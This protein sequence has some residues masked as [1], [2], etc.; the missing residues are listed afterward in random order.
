MWSELRKLYGP[1]VATETALAERDKQ[2]HR[3]EAQIEM[4]TSAVKQLQEAAKKN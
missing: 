2:I 3:M 1:V 4:L